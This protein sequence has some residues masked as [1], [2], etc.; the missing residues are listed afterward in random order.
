MGRD[1]LWRCALDDPGL[2][3]ENSTLHRIPL[4]LA[5]ANLLK[6]S[7][8]FKTGAF[9]FPGQRAEKP[10]SGMAL[11]MLMRRMGVTNAVPHGFRSSF[12]DWAGDTTDFPRELAEA[13]LSHVVGDA[14]EQAYRRG[15]A[16][17][18]RRD[19]MNA[20]ASFVE[21]RGSADNGARAHGEEVE[22]SGPP[23]SGT[24]KSQQ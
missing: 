23:H 11:E 18:K 13:A 14:V 8:G 19:L 9:V 10:L 22:G 15:D 21:G 1:R 3:D 6:D 17:A 7:H 16:L 4:S 12:R 20:W 5:A 2:A 24:R